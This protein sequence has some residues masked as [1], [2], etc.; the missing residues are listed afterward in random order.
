MIYSV[1]KLSTVAECDIV[2]STIAEK[3]AGI[4]Y[5][6]GL[7]AHRQALVA[8]S[9]AEITSELASLAIEIAGLENMVATLP[10]GSRKK[11]A[12]SDLDKAAFRKKVLLGRMEEQGTPA[13]LNIELELG[14]LEVQDAELATAETAVTARKAA[15]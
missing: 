5:R 2:L 4:L 12:Q 13:L 11:D 9:S 7:V 10:E 3:K 14:Q 6:K 15:L 1:E 8:K